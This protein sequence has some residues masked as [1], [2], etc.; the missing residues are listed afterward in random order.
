MRYAVACGMACRGSAG[1]SGLHRVAV[2]ARGLYRGS[3]VSTAISELS[4]YCGVLFIT[5]LMCVVKLLYCALCDMAWRLC[6]VV[7]REYGSGGA[8]KSSGVVGGKIFQAVDI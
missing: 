3:Y 8:V 6:V 4:S 7:R 1:V 5:S 2:Y